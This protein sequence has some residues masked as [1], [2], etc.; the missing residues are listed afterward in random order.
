MRVAFEDLNAHQYDLTLDR[1]PETG[2]P[3]TVG[4]L[5]TM[6]VRVESE[7][8]QMPGGLSAGVIGFNVWMTAVDRAV[9]EGHGRRTAT[10]TASSSICAATQAGSPRC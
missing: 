5:P 6:F 4:N 3:V 8:R 10:Q 7:R 1:R 2:E 9:P